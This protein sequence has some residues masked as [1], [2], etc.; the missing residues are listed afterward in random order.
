MRAIGLITCAATVLAAAVQAQTYCVVDTGQERCYGD[1]HELAYPMPGAAFYG[2]DAHYTGKTP[3]Y[4]DNADG[5]V[6][7]LNTGLMWTQD[8][9]EKKT[10]KRAMAEA[11]ACRIGGHDDWRLPTI[12]ELYSLMIFSGTDP[13]PDSRERN[14][15][16]P[17]IDANCF[18][19]QYGRE[20][21]GERIIDSQ[22]ATCSLYGSTTMG[23]NRTMFGVNFADGRIKG[24]PAE[25]TGRGP[26]KYY[27][28]YVRG[29]PQ[30]GTNRFIDNGDGTVSDEATGLIWQKADSARGMN[31]NDALVYAEQLELAGHDDWRLPNAKE[32]QSIV[33]YSRSP[34]ATGSAAIDPIFQCSAIT[35]EAGQMDFAFYWT[36]TTHVRAG[37]DGARAVYV[38]FGRAMGNMHGHWMDVHGA[39][40]QRSDPKAGES[41][42]YSQG[43][44]PQGD[45]IRILNYVRCVRGGAATPRASGPAL[46]DR[47]VGFPENSATR[48]EAPTFGGSGLRGE[49][50]QGGGHGFVQRLDKDGDGR[51]SREEFDGPQS[52]F[53]ALDKDHDGY[54]TEAEAPPPP[55]ARRSL[56]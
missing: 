18:K 31:W 54:L 44:G 51:V 24:Y 6:S 55:P 11:A 3:E 23:G 38:A 21:R 2:Q 4:R 27:A 56:R 53:P 41:S 8:P 12:K 50:P 25:R 7:D 17:F 37:G 52:H 39:G 42:R 26:A 34:D 15:L 9:G 19:F 29:N 49:R 47:A 30:Y 5:T 35:N 20:D 33:N 28:L 10:F 32:L 16:T 43:R 22:F 48:R 40:A 46:E 36:S 1:R 45:A 13:N 14:E